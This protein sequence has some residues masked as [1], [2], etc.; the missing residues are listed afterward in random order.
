MLL[1]ANAG[2]HRGSVE[3]GAPCGD[4]FLG[5]AVKTSRCSGIAGFIHKSNASS[6]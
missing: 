1:T 6:D 5:G 3:Q 2:A 4:C